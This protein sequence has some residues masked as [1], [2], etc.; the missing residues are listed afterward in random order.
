MP[1]VIEKTKQFIAGDTFFLSII[2]VL[3]VAGILMFTSA[4]FG[5]LSKNESKFY[6]VIFNQFIFGL[7]GG[8]AL[9]Y[10]FSRIP[11][12]FFRKHALY[13]FLGSVVLTAMVFIPHIGFAHGGARRWITLGF[14]SFQ[15]VEF[16]KI[17][18]LIYLA[19][20][21]SWAKHKINDFRY[22]IL[23]LM[24]LLGI[25]ALVLFKQPDTK[26]FILMFAA[27]LSMLF[28]SGVPMKYL[29]G[30]F[31]GCIVVLTILV[32]LTPYL[33]QRV[34]TFIHPSHDAA[35]SSYQLQQSLIAVGSGGLFGRGFGQSVQKWSYLPE[36]QGDSIF[37][38]IGEEF[39]FVGST[40][41]ILLFMAFTLRGLHVAYRA[42]DAFG[43]LFALGLVILIVAQ[44][45]MN[46]ASIIGVIPLTG[47]PLVFI[48][49]GGTS[50]A[51]TL[52]AIGIM[53]N[54]SKNQR[55]LPTT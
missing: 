36:P 27:G 35:G 32:L 6:G 34:E 2:G 19:A 33:R 55:K 50:L 40:L 42:P 23:P 9:L 54:I 37:A 5:I 45:M 14:V 39:G 4:S 31:G 28:A 41:L 38:V 10:I 29:L 26:S 13:F 3:L 30:I 1:R 7:V 25:V 22:G 49:H 44:S 21:L 48:S 47:V 15:P 12:T 24:I 43:R 20:W 11:Y 16:L 46:I 17:S 18:F 8:G 53:Q 51:I 52:A